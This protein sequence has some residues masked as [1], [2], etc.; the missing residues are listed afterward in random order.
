MFLAQPTFSTVIASTPLVSIDLVVINS[1][2]QVLLGQRLNRP[3]KNYWFVPGGR[4]LKNEPL[5]EAF[6][7]LTRDELGQEF[8]IAQA[9]LLG[10]FD[11]FYADNVFSDMLNSCKITTD[12]VS[13]HYV[14]IAFTLQV[15][16]LLTNLPLALQ[17]GGYQWF[18]VPSLLADPKVHLHTK[19]YFD[20]TYTELIKE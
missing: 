16:F 1:N 4:I 11:H 5:A 13:T 15:D 2:G 18:D 9:T 6:K 17:H 19:W 3:A 8:S 20:K 10:P 14:A 12:D 7:R